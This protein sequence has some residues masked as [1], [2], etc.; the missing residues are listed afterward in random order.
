MVKHAKFRHNYRRLRP[1]PCSKLLYVTA[2]HCDAAFLVAA[3][4]MVQ[5]LTAF[6]LAITFTKLE[7]STETGESSHCVQ[8][9]PGFHSD[10]QTTNT[11]SSSGSP[12]LVK[13]GFVLAIVTFIIGQCDGKI[14]AIL[15]ADKIGHRVRQVMRVGLVVIGFVYVAIAAAMSK[16]SVTAVNEYFQVNFPRLHS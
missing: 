3:R 14:Q 2:N 8:S 9:G 4:A 1:S 11:Q 16:R 6:A 13:T 10:I 5:L 12:E 15:G 7:V